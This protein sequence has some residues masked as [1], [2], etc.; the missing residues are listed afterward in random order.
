VRSA[1]GAVV[2]VLLTAVVAGGCGSDEGSALSQAQKGLA[3]I[4]SG[5]LSVRLTIVPSGVANGTTGFLLS[6]PFSLT[7]GSQPVM[8]LVYTQIAGPRRATAVLVSDGRG[9][10]VQSAGKTYA[11]SRA[12]MASLSPVSRTKGGLGE[13]GVDFDRWVRDA[14]VS[15]GPTLEGDPTQ[16]ISGTVDVA[17]ALDDI[18]AAGRRA[19]A[20]T[21]L[22]DAAKRSLSRSVTRSHAEVV[23]GRDDHLPRRIVLDVAFT[24]TQQARRILGGLRGASAH[25]SLGIAKPNMRVHVS[26]P[27]G[28]A[29]APR[30]PAG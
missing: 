6:G 12:Q 21:G 19:G 16:R 1:R 10:W 20:K 28:A 15:D 26:P 8:R 5:V 14:D 29:A 25:L 9:A 4:H 13:L 23:A 7:R 17:R 27:A 24:L 2:A 30:L 3:R 11:L 22:S 18:L